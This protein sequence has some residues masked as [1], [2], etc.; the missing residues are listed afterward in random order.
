VMVFRL[1]GLVSSFAT[2]LM[3]VSKILLRVHVLDQ[4]LNRCTLQMFT[5][6]I[7]EGISFTINSFV[8]IF[9]MSNFNFL[10]NFVPVTIKTL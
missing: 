10:V 8:K 2:F 7:R 6:F 1:H 3:C 9:L 4:F 5:A